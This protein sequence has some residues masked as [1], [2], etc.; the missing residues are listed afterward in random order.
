M[1]VPD[2]LGFSH[3]GPDGS[4]Y[5][6][7]RPPRLLAMKDAIQPAQA[8]LHA[9]TVPRPVVVGPGHRAKPALGRFVNGSFAARSVAFL[10]GGT[11]Y[12]HGSLPSQIAQYSRR[13]ALRGRR[14]PARVIFLLLPVLLP[15]P[16]RVPRCGAQNGD[17]TREFLAE[18]VRFELTGL[19][20]SGFQDR[21]N[22]PL[23]HLSAAR[24]TRTLP[25]ATPGRPW[26][27]HHCRPQ[28]LRHCHARAA[29]HAAPAQI[30]RGQSC[31]RPPEPT[32][33]P[34]RNSGSRARLGATRPAARPRRA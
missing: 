14:L 26:M 18:R 32:P 21:R 27:P 28:A 31:G 33:T 24:A 10:P 22:R 13:F 19:S 5:N 20:S 1:C 7:D 2:T 17:F 4:L 3:R 11:G 6:Q 8:P 9:S 29:P 15:V 30:K 34:E 23:C 16:D 12:C 25:R